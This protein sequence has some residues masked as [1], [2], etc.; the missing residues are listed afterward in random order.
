MRRPQT[1]MGI[2]S[3]PMT[4]CHTRLHL[5]FSA[6]LRI[7]QVSACKME[8]RSGI[9]LLMVTISCGGAGSQS[10]SKIPYQQLC[11]K[12]CAVSPP[13]YEHVINFSCAVSPP[14]VLLPSSAQL[15]LQLSLAVFV[16]F[17]VLT[18][19]SLCNMGIVEILAK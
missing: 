7:W 5:G 2:S 9:I 14:F 8:P 17:S 10:L 11:L 3:G 13:K 19:H 6:K 15:Q 16:S 4:Y 18:P 1:K 12:F